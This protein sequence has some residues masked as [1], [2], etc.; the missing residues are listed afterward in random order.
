MT[1]KGRR[2][3]GRETF[4]MAC[5]RFDFNVYFVTA[6]FDDDL[7]SYIQ[8]SIADSVTF[9]TERLSFCH[10]PLSSNIQASVSGVNQV[11]P[12]AQQFNLYFFPDILFWD[13]LSTIPSFKGV[14]QCPKEACKGRQLSENHW[15]E[16]QK[17]RKE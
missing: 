4:K 3:W 7:K 17:N 13:P 14:L 16:R 8:K 9:T 15:L 10:P 11:E 5:G 6:T 12:I 2:I 1:K